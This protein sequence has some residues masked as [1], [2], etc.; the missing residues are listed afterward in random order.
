MKNVKL[1][2]LFIAGLFAIMSCDS[3]DDDVLNFV[4]VAEAGPNQSITLP[5]GT[6]T[7]TGTGTDSDGEIRAYLWSQVSGPSATVISNPGNA[8]T[9]VKFYDAGTYI[10]QLMV[11]DNSGATGIDT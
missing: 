2:S 8:T 11:T 10:F 4:P 9:S 7:L 6:G 3:G 1:Y 5:A